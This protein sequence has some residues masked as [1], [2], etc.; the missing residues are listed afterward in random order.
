MT[1]GGD[2]SDWA[3]ALLRRAVGWNCFTRR[4]ELF[5]VRFPH[6]APELRRLAAAFEAGVLRPVIEE[7]AVDGFR[8]AD[9][10]RAAFRRLSGRRVQ[11]KLVL[12]L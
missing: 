6:S 8:S 4:H 2:F 5:W 9:P 7:V 10:V 3:C 12:V 1:L 11:G